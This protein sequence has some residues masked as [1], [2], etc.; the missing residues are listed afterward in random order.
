MKRDFFFFFFFSLSV[1]RNLKFFERFSM[2]CKES[3]W[4]E[5]NIVEL[6]I[7]LL[8]NSNNLLF[9]KLSQDCTSFFLLN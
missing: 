6:C 2:E 3:M 4:N 5:L 1:K 7:K 8:D 9:K